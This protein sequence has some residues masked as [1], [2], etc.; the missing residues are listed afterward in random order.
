MPS[1]ADGIKV[2]NCNNC[3]NC[4]AIF[5]KTLKYPC[6]PYIPCAVHPYLTLS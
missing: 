4:N 2:N 5:P 3:N 1:C 6:I